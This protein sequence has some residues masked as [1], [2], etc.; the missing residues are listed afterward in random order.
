M[1]RHAFILAVL[2][3]LVCILSLTLIVPD[4]SR[5]QTQQ[6]PP[7]GIGIPGVVC[8]GVTQVASALQHAL[9]TAP[10]GAKLQLPAGT[11]VLNTAL[12]ITRSITLEGAGLQQT[13]LSQTV[14][15]TPVLIVSTSYAQ[16]R[17]LSVTHAGHAVAGGD[18]LVVRGPSGAAVQGVTLTDVMA[19]RNWRGIVLGCVAYS[20][21]AHVW[22]VVNNSHGFEFMYEAEPGCGVQQW[23]IL[24]ALSQLNKGGGFWGYNTAGTGAIGPWLTQT[25]SFANDLGG[26]VFQGSPGHGIMDLRFHNILSSADNRKG[27]YLDTYGHGHLVSEPWIELTGHLAGYPLGSDGTI[28]VASHT[29][30]CL[31]VTSSNDFGVAITGG[32]YWSCSWSGL[33]LDGPYSTLVGGT[34]IANGQALDP[35]M[36]RRAGVHIGANGVAVNG[37]SFRYAPPAT[38]HFLHLSGA[39]DTISI[40]QNT[41]EAGLAEDQIIHAAEMTSNVRMPIQ[42]A[43]LFVHSNRIDAGG[44]M[45]YDATNGPTPLKSMRVSGGNFI[46]LNNA[47]S[48][49]IHS[50]SDVGTP[51]WP[52]RRGQVT[53]ADTNTAAGVAL[54][55]PEPNAAY[56][57]QLTPVVS[58]GGPAAGAY[59]VTQV[60]KAPGSF[61]VSLSAAPG[62]GKSVT[63]DWLVYR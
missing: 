21:A 14:T 59:T 3:R 18:G 38:L 40:G 45:L 52:Q 28:S 29:G 17:S 43:G 15:N 35:A 61:Q 54:V 19:L 1:G 25:V 16:V 32:L 8:D 23:D 34:S 12:T 26:Y 30:H 55:P 60:A 39:F 6:P 58:V 63:F 20:Q 2:A 47:G 10:L 49:V 51:S 22:S 4:H 36:G 46:M 33:A 11:C 5:A 42:P 31:E 48:A 62:V 44:L 13:T 53:I 7:S 24:H 27:L 56:F 41:Y 37:H 50:L 57:V 9:D